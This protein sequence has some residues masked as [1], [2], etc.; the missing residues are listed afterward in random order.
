MAARYNRKTVV[1]TTAPAELLVTVADMKDYLRVDDDCDDK[2]IRGFIK[3]ATD[4]TK[5]Y[6]QRS[7]ITETLTLTMDGFSHLESDHKLLELGAGVH[8]G[9][10]ST[11]TGGGN[12]L[13]LP[14]LP[15]QSITSIK[16]YDRDNVESTFAASNY[17]LDESGGRI[18]LNESTTWPVNLRHREAVKIEYISGYGDS[19]ED[20]PAP[21]LQAVQYFV[22]G[23]YD[24]RGVCDM[25]DKSKRIL[26]PYKIED[27]LAF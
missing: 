5:Q 8:V 22:H 1:I 24:C 2:L 26:S 19:P 3:S 12:E 25:P 15:I 16:T 20:V 7:L 10:R 6:L 11:L 14:F 4:L 17:N 23:M 18:Y 9:H 21:I 13:D 27:R